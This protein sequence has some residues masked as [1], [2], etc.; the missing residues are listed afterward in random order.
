M[1]AIDAT[2]LIIVFVAILFMVGN[3]TCER[4]DAGEYE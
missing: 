4:W 3:L 2:I 1:N